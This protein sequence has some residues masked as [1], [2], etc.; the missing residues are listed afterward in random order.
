MKFQYLAVIFVIIIMPIALVM[1]FY[2]QAQIDVINKQTTYMAKLNDATYDAVKAFQLNTT[3]SYYSSISDSKIRD[4]EA[5]INTFYNSLTSSINYTKLELQE[6][7]PAIVYTLYDG[8]YI[9]GKRYNVYD[10]VEINDSTGVVE[11]IE[12]DTQLND[13]NRYEYGLKPF[14]YYSCRYKKGNDDFVV[15]FTLDNFISIYGKINGNYESKS[16]YLINI[17]DCTVNSSG[18]VTAYKDANLSATENL[19]EYL[20]FAEKAKSEGEESIPSST[21]DFNN[22][23]YIY[24]V[25]N[26]QK[27]YRGK[28]KGG[29][30]R[31]FWFNQGEATVLAAP[32]E[33]LVQAFENKTQSARQYYTDAYN[34]SIWVNNNIGSIGQINIRLANTAE[35]LEFIA[36]EP[37]FETSNQDPEDPSSTFNQHRIAVIKNA[38]KTNLMAAINSYNSNFRA[39]EFALPELSEEEWDKVVNNVCV[40]AFVQGLPIGGKYF[41]SYTVIPNDKNNE[42]VDVDSVYIL[43]SDGQYHMPNCPELVEN[44]SY[45]DDI[46]GGYI[47]TSFS[48]QTSDGKY[49][50]KHVQDRNVR[51]PYT[52]CYHC[53]VNASEKYD[54][55]DDIFLNESNTIEGHNIKVLRDKFLTYLSREKYNLYKTTSYGA[56]T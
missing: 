29:E 39:T 27:I 17:N 5:S 40:I 47:N 43:T 19:S 16:G 21:S 31:Y 48:R 55:N 36:T 23:E 54:L 3:N 18:V 12:I 28:D 1:N 7:V 51:S 35:P 15:N 53:I 33:E 13:V 52:A 4:I 56:N 34:F 22:G 10:N 45:Q 6:Y 38:I 8:Y 37:I 41:N 26:S 32:A 30:E 25:Y 42:F 2:T 9:Y 24:I 50:Y 20:I 11:Q 44:T 46:V 14:V 49:Y